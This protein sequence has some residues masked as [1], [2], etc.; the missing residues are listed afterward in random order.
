M[1]N[2]IEML[3]GIIRVEKVWCVVYWLVQLASL[4]MVACLNVQWQGS[5]LQQCKMN[6]GTRHVNQWGS[7]HTATICI[8]S[9]QM[10]TNHKRPNVTCSIRH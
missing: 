9:L 8:T 4:T 6:D 10:M 5:K 3:F 7:V 1:C 2:E